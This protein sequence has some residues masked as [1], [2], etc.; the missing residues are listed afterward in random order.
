MTPPG[1]SKAIIAYITIVGLLIAISMNKDEPHDFATWHIKN[2]FGLTLMFFISVAMSYQEYLL[3][4][5]RIFFFG[6]MFF[7]L[8]SLV[9]AI[10][11]KK[12]GI[13]FLSDKFDSWFTF[14]N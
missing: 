14:L 9:M 11:N 1:K 7:W 13:P 3:F 5:G 12:V 10:A 8:F 2:M 4:P 6:S